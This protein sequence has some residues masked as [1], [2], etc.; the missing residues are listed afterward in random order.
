MNKS[1]IIIVVGTV[2]LIL[3][4][5]VLLLVA[6]QSSPSLSQREEPVVTGGPTVIPPPEIPIEND[7]P[8]P[9]QEAI[10]AFRAD[11]IENAP[12]VYVKN[13]TPVERETFLLESKFDAANDRYTFV[14]TPRV[15]SLQ[16]VQQDV[17]DW[18][19]EIR[20]PTDKIDQLFI[21]YTT[22]QN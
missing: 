19:L 21:E 7:S 14:I 18:F 15:S 10:D 2:L 1:K 17:L 22:A 6:I 9:N 5:I 20:Y 13:Y 16:Q 11:M 3:L 12:D 4:T 8:P